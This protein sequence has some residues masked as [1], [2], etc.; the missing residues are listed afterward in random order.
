MFVYFIYIYIYIYLFMAALGLCCFTWAFCSRGEQELLSSCGGSLGILR[1]HVLDYG[2][3]FFFSFFCFTLR[4][5][6]SQFLD[7]GLNLDHS[8][9]SPES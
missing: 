6:G 1:C 7:Q 3:F 5:S 9:E 4:L 8:S 2:F